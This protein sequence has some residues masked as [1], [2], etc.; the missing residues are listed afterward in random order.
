[1]RFARIFFTSSA[2]A[3]SIFMAK[4]VL[5][6]TLLP[7]MYAFMYSMYEQEARSKVS[8]ETTFC[9]KMPSRFKF[10]VTI[11]SNAKA[12]NTIDKS[13]VWLLTSHIATLL[14][15]LRI[16]LTGASAVNTSVL[17]GLFVFSPIK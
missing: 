15:A 10:S 8:G 12:N 16:L 17:F 4:S 7:I 13:P 11:T 1:M 2:Y 14:P 9:Q 6:A 3:V 5:L